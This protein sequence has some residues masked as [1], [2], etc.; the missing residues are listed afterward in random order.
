MININDILRIWLTDTAIWLQL[1]DKRQGCEL[2]V[3]Y[4]GLAR[5]SSLQRE[6]YTISHF[7]LHWPELDEDLSFSGF[8]NKQL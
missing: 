7:G 3:D 4:P 6:K 5:A 8:F 1:K 2:F